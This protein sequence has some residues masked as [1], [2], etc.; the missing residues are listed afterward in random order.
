MGWIGGG[1]HTTTVL[2]VNPNGS[3]TVFDNDDSTNGGPTFLGIHTVNYDTETIPT[4]ITIFR[5]TTDHLYLIDGS[6]GGQIL[7]GTLQ[8]DNEIIT[9]GET[10]T[11]NCG[12]LNDVVDITAAS[13]GNHDHQ[14]RRWR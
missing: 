3:I 14:R 8:Y 6:A 5:L 11:V 2:S 10:Q 13:T 9:S 4:T 7:N 12:P 1:M